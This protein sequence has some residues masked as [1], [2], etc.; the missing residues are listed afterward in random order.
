VVVPRSFPLEAADHLRANGIDVRADGALFDR[1]RRRKTESEL[2]GIK[3]ALRASEQAYDRARELLRAGGELSS[4]DLRAEIT[5][6]LTDAGMTTPELVIVSHGPQTAIGHEP[7]H[8]RLEAGEPIVIDLY[9]QDPES[10]CYSDMTRTFCIGDP[11]EP[12][13]TYHRLCLEAFERVYAAIRPGVA[14]AEIFGLACDV[15][16]REGYPTQRTKAEGDV[17]DEG[18]YHSLGHGVGLEVHELPALGRMGE[19][20]LAGDVLAVEPGLYT[21]DFGGCCLEDLVLV[22]ESGCEVL[23]EY[24]YDLA[25]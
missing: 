21:K 19:E 2:A 3:R 4:E 6:A 5:R 22:T 16:E 10:G 23:T 1:R 18:F 17:L 12:L 8:G 11:P 24:P 14:G 25:P 13:V 15:F 7:G 9:P 20:L